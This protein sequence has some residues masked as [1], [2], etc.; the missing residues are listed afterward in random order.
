MLEVHQFKI[1]YTVTQ[2]WLPPQCAPLFIV[3]FAIINFNW[4]WMRYMKIPRNA[5]LLWIIKFVPGPLL[6]E[7]AGKYFQSEFL[8]ALNKSQSRGTVRLFGKK[9]DS[10][11]F[12]NI[13]WNSIYHKMSCLLFDQTTLQLLYFSREIYFFLKWGMICM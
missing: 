8:F 4:F 3:V 7:I 9:V 11:F 5:P 13:I 1:R 12:V 2:W 6:N 10:S